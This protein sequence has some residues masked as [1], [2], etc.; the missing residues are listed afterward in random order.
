M[1]FEDHETLTLV[2]AFENAISEGRQPYFDVEDLELILDYYL[3]TGSFEQTK[4]ALEIAQAIHPLAFTFK[5]KEVQLDIAMKDYT[6]AEAKLNHLEGLN[7]RSTELLIARATILMHRGNTQK[8]LQLLDE[9]LAGSDDPVEVLQMIADTH[10][11]QGDYP[12][13]IN[14]LVRWCRLEGEDLDEGALYQL[15]MCLDFTNEYDRAINLFESLT[16]KEPYNPLLWY[17]LGAFQ[18]RKD[19]E[20][21]ALEMFQWA[22]TADETFHAAYFEKGRIH[23]RNEEYINALTAYKQSVTK[24]CPAATCISA[25]AYSK[26]NLAAP[27]RPYGNS[28]RPSPLNQIWTMSIWSARVYSW[29]WSAM[30]KRS[31][32]TKRSGWTKPTGRRMSWISWS[33]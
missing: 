12:R 2:H 7:M 23:E 9:A 16:Q 11:S 33:V 15:A 17:Q 28:T 22:I 27:M 4:N 19:N 14:I 1:R 25:S 8:G 10:L 30:Q 31:R 21:Q 3:D 29:N 24:T 20:T 18:L 32:I 5:I 26:L 6:R 13:A